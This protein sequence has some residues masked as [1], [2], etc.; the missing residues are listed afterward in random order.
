M[1]DTFGFGQNDAGVGGRAQKFKADKGKTYR[2]GFAW[3]AGIEDGTFSLKNMTPAEGQDELSVTPK[4]IRAQRNFIKDVGYVINQGPEWT[5]L[6]GEQPKLMIATIVIS[7][8]LGKNGQP[9]KE[10]LF[11]D[12]PDVMAWIFGGDKYE[13]LK[14]QHQSGYPMW[15]WDVQ[16]DCEDT[17]FQ[18]LSFLPAK[19]CIFREMLKSDAPQAKGIVN[20]ILEQV[21][22]LAP[23][24][25]REIGAKLSLDQLREKMGLDTSSPVSSVMGAD[26]DVDNILGNMLDD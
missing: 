18:K 13:K 12:M 6:A 26:A 21:R 10:S 14:K 9:T 4:F 8:P 19:Q 23:R 2:L 22:A 11:G 25:E 15:E 1:S 17:T 16:A 20:H 3:W 24:L 7:W 5:K